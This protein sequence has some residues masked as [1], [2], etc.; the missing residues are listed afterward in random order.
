MVLEIGN[1]PAIRRKDPPG[2]R[3]LWWPGTPPARSL[4]EET[5]ATSKNISPG[6]KAEGRSTYLYQGGGAEE[7]PGGDDAEDGGEE[8]RRQQAGHGQPPPAGLRPV[9]R[10]R[11][12]CCAL[13]PE[14]LWRR[15]RRR[16]TEGIWRQ[17]KRP[18]PVLA[19]GWAEVA[20][21]TSFHHHW[22][23]HVRPGRKEANHAAG[24][25]GWSHA[26]GFSR[27]PRCCREHG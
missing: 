2:W 20:E 14:E 15:S 7:Q 26:T 21:V 18:M 4:Q 1:S 25:A 6:A 24:S 27:R 17:S 22:K 11:L 16:S 5:W 9:C 19:R 10:F 13:A 8:A 12:Q 3:V 23:T